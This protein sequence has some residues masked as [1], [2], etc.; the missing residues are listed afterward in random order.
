[1]RVQAEPG[2]QGQSEQQNPGWGAWAAPCKSIMASL[3][4]QGPA[5]HTPASFDPQTQARITKSALPP[6][7][8]LRIWEKDWLNRRGSSRD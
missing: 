1:M 3:F 7:Q 4:A 5:E 6:P 8:G 2:A